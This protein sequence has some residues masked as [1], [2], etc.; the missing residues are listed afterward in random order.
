MSTRDVKLIDSSIRNG[1]VYFAISDADFFPADSI[2]DRAG[3][4]HKGV[5]VTFAGAGHVF[6]SDIR[7]SS[8]ARLSPRS[9]FAKLLKSVRAEEG[10]SLRFTRLAEREYKVEYLG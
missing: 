1:R 10:G 9:S 7:M 2:G 8:G 4:G 5:V 6:V 3:D